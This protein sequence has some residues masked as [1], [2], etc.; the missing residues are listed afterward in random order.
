M[1][2]HVK[3]NKTHPADPAND[4]AMLFVHQKYNK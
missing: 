3:H 4:A 1:L 2:V